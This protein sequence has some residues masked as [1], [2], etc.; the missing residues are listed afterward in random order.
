MF[1]IAQSPLSQL[2]FNDIY[3]SLSRSPVAQPLNSIRI[4]MVVLEK[5]HRVVDHVLNGPTFSNENTV[6]ELYG[7]GALCEIQ[8]HN[9]RYAEKRAFLLCS[10]GIRYKSSRFVLKLEIFQEAER[11]NNLNTIEAFQQFV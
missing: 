8:G 9:H 11:A 1:F 2:F 4:G 3:D 7:F 6:P 5:V 10:P